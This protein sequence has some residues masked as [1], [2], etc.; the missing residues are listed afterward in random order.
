MNAPISIKVGDRFTVIGYGITHPG[1]ARS[2]GVLRSAELVATSRPDSLDVR[3]T[4]PATRNSRR[5]LGACTGDSGAP[6]FAAN[7]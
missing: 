3:L 2:G 1:D 6:V 5:G 4:D 7:A